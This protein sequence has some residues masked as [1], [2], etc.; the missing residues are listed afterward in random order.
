[1]TSKVGV[2]ENYINN[3]SSYFNQLALRASKRFSSGLQFSVNYQHSRLMEKTT[4][5]NNNPGAYNLE[6]RVSA[7][8]RPNRLVVSQSYELP[9]GKGRHYLGGANRFADAVIGGWSVAT[10]YV[11]QSG[12]PLGWGNIIYY[13]CLLYTSPSPRDRQKSRMPSSA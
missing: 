6:K 8:D 5:L 1:M 9:F 10:I 12:G 7:S 11:Y 3:G 13:G 4:Y 2:T